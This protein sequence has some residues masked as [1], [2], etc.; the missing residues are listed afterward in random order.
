LTQ[1]GQ[2]PSPIV[3]LQWPPA[4][5]GDYLI[6]GYQVYRSTPS[7]EAVRRGAADALVSGL[8]LD[9]PVEI[10]QAYDYWVLAVDA[11]GLSGPASAVARLDLSALPMEQLA[12]PAP[13]DVTAASRRDDVLLSWQAAPAWVTAISGY[14]VWKA[15]SVQALAMAAPL[16]LS[17][18]S[19]VDTPPV[20][21]QPQWYAVASIDAA[22][23]VSARSV[24]V[25]ASATGTL[26]PGE[27]LNLSMRART[28][29]VALTW[30]GA[31]AGTAPVSG[32]LLRRRGAESEEWRQ[33]AKLGAERRDY[34]DRAPGDRGYVYALA[35]FDSEGNTGPAAYV[36]AS[37]SAKLLNKTLIITMPTAYANHKDSDRGLNLNVIFDFYVGSLFESYTNPTTE[38]VRTGAFQPLQI[39]TVSTDTKLALLDDRG[40]IPGLATGLYI[41]ALINFGQPSGAQTIGVSSSGSGGIATLGNAYAV[42]SKRF[43]PGRPGAVL[44]GGVLVG[45]L[46]NG[47]SEALPTDWQLTARHL[48]P[49]GDLPTL[50]SRFLNP[51]LG[52]Q[53]AQAPHMAFG[54]V[55]VPFTVPLIFT[56]WRTGL[57]LEYMAPLPIGAEYA[58]S[59]LPAPAFDPATQLPWMLN[60]HVDNLPLFGFEFGYFHIPGGF[61]LIAFYHIPDLTWSW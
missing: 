48:L 38:Q 11:R 43:W 18:T 60:I 24:T 61:Q 52:A 53:V 46:A 1:G 8:S 2:A 26:P 32:Y 44:H 25:S 37:P 12:P 23:R 20:Q 58:P 13:L 35:A 7:G 10:G 39:G 50:M 41:S 31:A 51:K 34:T 3:R 27:P 49:G 29:R 22:G 5:P 56:Q 14:R 55:Q 54:G 40:L 59:N 4:E 28:E 42:L 16:D 17:D 19:L 21:G 6:A 15:G 9:D 45:G 33:L 47:I 30:E 57:R 36:A